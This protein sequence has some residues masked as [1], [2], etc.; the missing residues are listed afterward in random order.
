M[1]KRAGATGQNL[2]L[3]KLYMVRI[4]LALLL[5]AGAADILFSADRTPL[6]ISNHYSPYNKKRALRPHTR[7]IVLHTTEGKDRGSLSVVT[8]SGLAH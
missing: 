1:E 4:A 5:A 8:R 7:Y 6:R 2:M 3:L